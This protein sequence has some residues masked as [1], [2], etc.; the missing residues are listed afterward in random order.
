[1]QT[2]RDGTRQDGMEREQ[3]CP[4]METRRKKK[5]TERCGTSR[6]RRVR[7]YQNSP[8]TRPWN[9]AFHPF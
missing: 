7:R 9:S 5:E 3:R 2:G 8:K 1:M 6:S 4:R